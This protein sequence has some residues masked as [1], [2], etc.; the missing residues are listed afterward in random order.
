M[1]FVFNLLCER[2]ICFLRNF[3]LIIM[4]YLV[5]MLISGFIIFVVLGINGY[6]DSDFI[7]GENMIGI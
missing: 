5:G 4:V 2:C 6:I 7:N 3:L 1:C